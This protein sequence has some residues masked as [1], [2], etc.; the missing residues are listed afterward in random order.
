MTGLMT[1]LVGHGL[2]FTFISV[3]A[4]A[5]DTL[6]PSEGFANETPKQLEGVGIEEHLGATIDLD[7]TFKNE[8]GELVPLRSYFKDHK[9]VLLSLAYYTCPSL[10][11]FHLNGLLDVFK[12]LNAPLGHEFNAVVVSIDARETPDVARKKK[13]NYIKSYGRPEGAD[14]WH[15][16]VG[17][18]TKIRELAKQVGFNYHWDE[19]QKQW[20]HAAAAYVIT[21]EGKISR[22]LYGID[23]DPQTLRLSMVEASSG[24]VGTLV[25]KLILY[26]FHFDPKASKYTLYA[27][28]VMRAGGMAIIVI[29]TAF[30]V[31]FWVR[32]RREGEVQR[33]QGEA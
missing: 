16:L 22:Y 23:F 19:E 28:N 1:G 24:R 3:P 9:P 6:P 21:P 25:D 13:E 26:C 18:E 11:N 17:E 4:W 29:L 5:R 27:F 20:A 10:C 12:K 14:G 8:Q 33:V 2:A 7:L 31:P 32:N 30:L 15:F